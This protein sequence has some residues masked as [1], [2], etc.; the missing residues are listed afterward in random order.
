VAVV[1]EVGKWHA[2]SVCAVLG[3][4]QGKDLRYE[5]TLTEAR[6]IATL[7]QEVLHMH[8]VDSPE[9]ASGIVRSEGGQASE[10]AQGG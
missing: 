3:I 9:Q 4:L 8:P 10:G 5:V 1:L 6:M 7:E 2:L